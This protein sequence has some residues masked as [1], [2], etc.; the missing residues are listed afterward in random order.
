M[1][2]DI[3]GGFGVN[4]FDEEG[5]GLDAIVEAVQV[6]EEDGLCLVVLE[7]GHSKGA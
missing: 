2:E 7:L 6:D 4:Y 1:G 5:V 3:G